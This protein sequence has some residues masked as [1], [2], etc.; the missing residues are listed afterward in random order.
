MSKLLRPGTRVAVFGD[1]HME[2]LGPRLSRSLP[3][4][5][6]VLTNVTARRGWS[7]PGYL[8]AGDVPELVR[9]ADVVVIELG[10]NDAS[11]RRSPERHAEE[12]G[13]LLDQV[14]R[15]KKVLWISPG[16]TLRADLESYR[17]PIRGAQKKVVEEAGGVWID[18]R[19]LTSSGQL[20][21][22]GVHFSAAGYDQWAAG[23]Q[24]KLAAASTKAPRWWIGPAVAGGAALFAIGAYA[25]S[26]RA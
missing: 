8:S 15:E 16:V 7:V 24:S 17:G 20:R 5:G 18:S 6:V 2:A 9:G 19:P 10:G 12:V 21:S 14:G 13:R 4:L 26:Q 11:L 25:W 3:S 1:S 23:L 22:D